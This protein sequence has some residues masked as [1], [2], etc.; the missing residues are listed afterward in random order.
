MKI[1]DVKPF[2][3]G[4]SWRNIIFIKVYTDEGI[5][6]IGEA[7]IQNREEGVLGFLDGAV[8]R[9]VIGSDPFNIEDLWLRMYRNDFWRG[10]VIATTVMS[11]VEI[12]CWDIVGK[13]VGQP[14]YKLLG[15]RCREKIKA[16]ANGWYKAERTPEQF[17]EL[18]KTVI[19]RGYRALKVDPF[20]DGSYELERAEKLRSIALVEAIR[21][22]VG[23]D[24]DI[25]IE[26]HGRFS[27]AT[28][29]DLAID[30][31]K[32]KP[33]WFEEP[34]PPEDMLSL[35]Y[36][37]SKINIPVATGERYF[38]HYEFSKLFEMR[39]ADI[40]QPDII[41]AGGL[42]ELKKIAAMADAHFT[43][44]APHNSNGP[45]CT[46]A[47]VHFAACTTNF[48]IQECF[49]DFSEPWVKEAVPGVPEVKD[50]YF[51]LPDRPGLGIE[52]NEDLINEHPYRPGFMNI[53]EK[54]WQKRESHKT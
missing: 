31:E 2:V 32:F 29:I 3:L 46:A 40:I 45:V 12:A 14:V 16:Y 25:Y 37:R 18:A 10:G 24:V 51:D 17:A 39:A 26:G 35:A 8:R 43:V 50:G 41:H 33:G 5:T 13:T 6:G 38:T 54:G 22:A 15:G 21:D 48:K 53:W 36:V 34:I 49:D 28:A 47:S 23:P 4:T 9:H 1:K 20:G 27:P 11:A 52:L 7:T 42:L 30:L 19:A 44:M